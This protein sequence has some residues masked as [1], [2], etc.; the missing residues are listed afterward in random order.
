MTDGSIEIIEAEAARLGIKLDASS[1]LIGYAL[2][3][4]PEYL[5]NEERIRWIVQSLT[6]ARRDREKQARRAARAAS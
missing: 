2:G 6:M 5:G 4:S 3:R 1:I